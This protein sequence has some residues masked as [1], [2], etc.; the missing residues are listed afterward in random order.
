MFSLLAVK[1]H[2]L[3]QGHLVELIEIKYLKSKT[4]R[5][6]QYVIFAMPVTTG[7]YL[8]T[9]KVL[10]HFIQMKQLKTFNKQANYSWLT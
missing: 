4:L 5:R 7:T 1:L 10:S 2:L 9:E 6:K 3:G 8:P